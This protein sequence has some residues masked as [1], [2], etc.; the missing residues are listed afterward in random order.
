LNPPLIVAEPERPFWGFGE[1]LVTAAVFLVAQQFTVMLAY[2]E[3]ERYASSGAF[4]LG[5]ESIAYLAVF[6]AL[7]LLFARYRRPLL[8]SLA[9]IRQPFRPM[10]L[11]MVGVILSVV[12]VLLEQ[13]L[14][15]PNVP[16]PFEKLLVDAPSRILI[17]VFGVTFA[18]AFEELLFRGLLQ[19]V[20]IEATGV[21]PGI[22]ITSVAFGA[23]HLSQNAFIWQSGVLIALVGFVL[24]TVRH[25]S[26]STRASAIVHAAYNSLPC[27]TLLLTG[28][29]SFHK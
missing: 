10:H 12:T 6:A 18:P 15:T 2:R 11:V 25:I 5:V 20:L 29:Q 16:T 14:R 13:L 4:L 28:G 26:G 8:K 19:P 17:A 24:G 1:I 3:A 23:V 21:L 22:L 9:W 7:A 27:L